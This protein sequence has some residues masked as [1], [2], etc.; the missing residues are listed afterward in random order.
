MSTPLALPEQPALPVGTRVAARLAV[1]IAR[2]LAALPP[3]RIRA[4]LHLARVGAAPATADQAGAARA[5][6]VAV[7]PR[8][9]GPRCLQR[10]LA[11]VLLCRLKG[12]WPT[13]HTGV[14]T[15]P[16]RAHAWVEAAGHPIGEPEPPGYYTPTLTVPPRERGRPGEEA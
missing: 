3:R 4:V 14:R 1:A 5:A 9:A 6:V 15:S 7:S 12:S 16:F 8:C 13:W 11:T 10:S 2:V